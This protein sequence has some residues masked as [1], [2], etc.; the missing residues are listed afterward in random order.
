M[1]RTVVLAIGAA[2]LVAASASAHHSFPSFYF[3][4]RTM[5]VEGEL[6]EFDYRAPHAWVHVQGRDQDGDPQRFAA[7][8]ANPSRLGRENVTKE[9][10]RPGD[11]VIISGAPGRKPGEHRLHLKSIERPSDGWKWAGM[12]R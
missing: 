9:T 5:T 7:E 3:E 1:T 2:A 6:V 11:H 12:R 10:L 4:D 8:W